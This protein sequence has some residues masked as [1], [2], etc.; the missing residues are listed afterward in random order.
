MTWVKKNLQLCAIF[1]PDKVG[2]AEVKDAGENKNGDTLGAKEDDC[3]GEP[4]HVQKRVPDDLSLGCGA[5]D[6]L[7]KDFASW[8]NINL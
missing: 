2:K 8:N 5:T 7:R 4:A 6:A 3:Q 1:G